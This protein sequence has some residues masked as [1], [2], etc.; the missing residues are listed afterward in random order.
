MDEKV[1][2]PL[3][4]SLYPS[5]FPSAV[6]PESHSFMAMSWKRLEPASA[7]LSGHSFHQPIR[8]QIVWVSWNLYLHVERQTEVRRVQD[9]QWILSLSL[10]GCMVSLWWRWEWRMHQWPCLLS[11][12][13][14]NT[15]NKCASMKLDVSL[16]KKKVSGQCFL[17]FKTFNS[18]WDLSESFENCY[19]IH[20]VC[21]CVYICSRFLCWIENSKEQHFSKWKPFVTLLLFS[22]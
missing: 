17:F 8:T 16:P 15:L 21:V 7:K 19:E 3:S 20:C 10:S 11:S 22:K 6:P 2:C 12:S 9:L 14:L 18:E 5:V 13:R 4:H 1:D